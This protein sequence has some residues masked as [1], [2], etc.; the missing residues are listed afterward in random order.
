MTDNAKLARMV[1]FGLVVITLAALAAGTLLKLRGVDDG[2]LTTVL[3]TGVG[4]LAGFLARGTNGNGSSTP[5]A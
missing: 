3:A 1:T 5:D 2:N 4:A